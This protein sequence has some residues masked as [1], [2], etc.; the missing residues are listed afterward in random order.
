[1]S[2]VWVRGRF[3]LFFVYGA[4]GM[5]NGGFTLMTPYELFAYGRLASGRMVAFLNVFPLVMFCSICDLLLERGAYQ[6]LCQLLL[7]KRG[8]QRMGSFTLRAT[9]HESLTVGFLCVSLD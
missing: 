5:A 4:S 8:Y 3:Q 6:L 9:I 2:G 1:M 7:Q